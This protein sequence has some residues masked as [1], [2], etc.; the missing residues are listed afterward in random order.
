M[1]LTFEGNTYE[2]E[3]PKV[4]EDTYGGIKLYFC[5]GRSLNCDCVGHGDF[6]GDTCV[7]WSG[8]QHGQM[9]GLREK[10]YTKQ[11]YIDYCCKLWLSTVEG[12]LEKSKE[13]LKFFD[14]YK[15]E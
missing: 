12:R 11:D 14:T 1:K 8:D 4:T 10:V 13:T 15:K 3:P 5:D 2:F 6:G 9:V 7:H